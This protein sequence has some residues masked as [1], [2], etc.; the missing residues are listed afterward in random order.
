MGDSNFDTI[1]N[2]SII[3]LVIAFVYYYYIYYYVPSTLKDGTAYNNV[4]F[5][6][7]MEAKLNQDWSYKC[8][9]GKIYRYDN[10]MMR[11]YPND[12]IA[13]SYDPSGSWRN[14]ASVNCNNVTFGPDLEKKLNQGWAYM[15]HNNIPDAAVYRYDNG[16][17]RPY[18]D[19][20]TANKWDSNWRNGVSRVDCSRYEFGPQMTMNG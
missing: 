11:L 12:E 8:N 15:C 3:V 9:D 4:P 13:N 19:E 18:P 10:G 14:A 2:I 20:A 5:G 6:P 1:L 7:D 17:L 16:K